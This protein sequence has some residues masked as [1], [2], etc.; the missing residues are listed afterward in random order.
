MPAE[1]DW[2]RQWRGQGV[3]VRSVHEALEAPGLIGSAE[4]GGMRVLDL[5]SGLGGFSQAFLERGHEVIRVDIEHTFHPTICSDVKH[6]PLKPFPRFDVILAAPP[7]EEFSRDF[8]PWLTGDVDKGMELVYVTRE[9]IDAFQPQFWVVE[10]VKGA[11]KYFQ[12]VFGQYRQRCGSRFLWGIFPWF[13]CRDELCYGK[14]KLPPSPLRKALRSKIPY[15]VS[16]RLCLRIETA[17]Q[18]ESV[19]EYFYREDQLEFNWQGEIGEE[20]GTH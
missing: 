14:V 13:P 12:G 20:H 7:C 18:N 19:M 1:Q 3:V 4:G 9:V 16:Y 6:L 8:M 11:I 17:M 15:E 5:F 10:N 2:H